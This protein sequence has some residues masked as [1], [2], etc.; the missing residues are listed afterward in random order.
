MGFICGNL[1]VLLA[2]RRNGVSF[3]KTLLIGRQQIFLRPSEIKS[4]ASEFPEFANEIRSYTPAFGEFSEPWFKACM[5]CEVV[6][7]IDASGF[8]GASLVHDMNLD[9]AQ[10]SLCENVVGRYDS[11]IDAGSLEHIFNTPVAL[12]NC[13]Q[14]VRPGGFLCLA[15]VAN[16]FCGHGFYQFS[17]ELFFRVLQPENGFDHLEVLLLCHPY[18]GA[19]LSRSQRIYR[20]ND[21]LRLGHRVGLVTRNPVMVIASA[22]RTQ[23]LDMFKSPPQQ[24]DYRKLWDQD[25]E[26]LV[27]TDDQVVRS[28][29][30]IGRV[31]R[32]G[33]YLLRRIKSGL[34][35][36][37]QHC[38]TGIEQRRMYS[39]TNRSHFSVWSSVDFYR[40]EAGINEDHLS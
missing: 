11:V 27:D 16:N 35:M 2:Q 17:P 5:G 9:V 32:L 40:A 38:L 39:L 13:M 36:D 20:V 28:S 33:G 22:Q 23:S 26:S 21:P 30:S 6:D 15:S 3:S 34:P 18:P 24:S 14:M 10:S 29:K 19:E 8:E 12:K 1:R 4:L 25:S 31:R 7:S 37:W